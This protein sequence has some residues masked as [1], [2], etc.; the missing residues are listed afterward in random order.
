[1]IVAGCCCTKQLFLTPIYVMSD[2][3]FVLLSCTRI[4]RTACVLTLYCAFCNHVL[5]GNVM[6]NMTS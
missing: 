6:G 1:M 2:V 4:L 3:A 5:F